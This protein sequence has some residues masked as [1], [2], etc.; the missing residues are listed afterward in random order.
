MAYKYLYEKDYKDVSGITRRIFNTSEELFDYLVKTG[1]TN[2]NAGFYSA[3][4]R[5]N[6]IEVKGDNYE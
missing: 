1:E 4:I 5:L 3:E 2:F 6:R